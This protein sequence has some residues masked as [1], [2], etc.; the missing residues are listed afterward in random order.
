[1]EKSKVFIFISLLLILVFI[2]PLL[3][4]EEDSEEDN[5]IL[6]DIT[7]YGEEEKEKELLN[8]DPDV[9]AHDLDQEEIL[10]PAG[11][12]EDLYRVIQTLPGVVTAGD[13]SSIMYIRGGNVQETLTFLD[14]TLI[15]NPYHMGIFSIF[16]NDLVESVDF[17][18]G[19]FPAIYPNV[20]SGIV[21]V[22]YREG[23]RDGISGMA[24]LSLISAKARLE[25]PYLGEKGSYLLSARRTY[26]D[27]ILAGLEKVDQEFDTDEIAVPSFYDIYGKFVQDVTPRN[28]LR[29]SLLRYADSVTLKEFE[30]PMNANAEPWKIEFEDVNNIVSLWWDFD[31]MPSLDIETGVSYTF[32][33]YNGSIA[34][35]NPIEGDAEAD[36]LY[37]KSG[38]S[39]RPSSNHEIKTGVQTNQ[40][41]INIHSLIPDS[42]LYINFLG[43]YVSPLNSGK[44]PLDFKEELF[45]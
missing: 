36:I 34:G 7:I 29:L 9:S 16:N 23:K 27:L 22:H 10:R 14:D 21:D 18:A 45:D 3:A 40:V 43:N 39:I 13:F 38:A 25:G 26:Y 5:I 2:S 17:Y 33:E 32:V 6:P 20:L 4:A 19:G 12:L 11:S 37:F 15:L 31:I 24:D 35:N 1:M 44:L 8:R 42:I 28:K 41:N 30:D